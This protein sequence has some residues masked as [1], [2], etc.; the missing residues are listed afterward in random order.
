MS[1]YC[2][3]SENAKK[4]LQKIFCDDNAILFCTNSGL[5]CMKLKVFIRNS[6]N[7]S[8]ICWS[9]IIP[10]NR[11]FVEIFCNLFLSDLFF[12]YFFD[13]KNFFGDFGLFSEKSCPAPFFI[14]FWDTLSTVVCFFDKCI[15]L[16]FPIL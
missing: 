2:I 3:H 16:C 10:I 15:F 5:I 7:K 4:A 13:E 12:F 9:A 8:I 6:T 14:N 11:K 1:K